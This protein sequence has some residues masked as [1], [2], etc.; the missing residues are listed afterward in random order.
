LETPTLDVAI[1]EAGIRQIGPED[2][3][4]IVPQNQKRV[5]RI[6]LC[7]VRDTDAADTLTQECFLKAFRKCTSFRGESSLTT[8]LT[9]IAVNL[10]R[11]HHRNR[12]LAFW[13]RL[14]PRDEAVG[15]EPPDPGRS[16][17]KSLIDGESVKLVL[18]A[19]ERLPERQRT[20][21]LLRFVEEMSLEEIAAAMGLDIGTVKSHLFRSTE[22]IRG[23]CAGLRK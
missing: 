11:D 2:F 1:P 15:I 5:Y 6:L 7:L 10:A 13:K 21:F 3:A 19:V 12:K 17:E 18:S 22:T 9:R 23:R 8:W 14:R 4:W 16:Q 20:V